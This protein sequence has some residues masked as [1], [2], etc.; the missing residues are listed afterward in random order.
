[1]DRTLIP[2]VFLGLAFL[3]VW[4]RR[5]LKIWGPLLVISLLLGLFLGNISVLG[6]LILLAWAALWFLYVKQ[7]KIALFIAIVILSF[8]FKFHWFP[9]FFPLKLTPRFMLGLEAPCAFFFPLALLVP[10]A[11]HWN[12][13]K[14]AFTKGLWLTV[15]GIGAMALVATTLGTVHWQFTLPS[16]PAIRYLNNLVLVAIP[17]E[18]FYR[19]FIQTTLC[20]FFHNTKKGNLAALFLTSFLFALTHL[21]WSPS[22]AIL[23]FTFIAGLLYGG[24]YLLSGKIESAILCHFLLNFIH[25]TFFNYHAM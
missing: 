8:G 24:V 16:M 14:I 22:L 7:P 4:V 25:M 10:V 21:Y 6:L 5:D 13:W 15:A 2:F 9:G 1:M 17:E 12:D 23:G 18:A 11:A 3:S 19:G 20:R